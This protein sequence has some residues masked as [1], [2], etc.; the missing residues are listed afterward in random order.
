MASG[1]IED[2]VEREKIR[3]SIYA[4]FYK[5]FLSGWFLGSTFF[6]ALSFWAAGLALRRAYGTQPE[7]A[8][9]VEMLMFMLACAF[10]AMCIHRWRIRRLLR[11]TTI[12][13]AWLGHMG[14]IWFVSSLAINMLAMHALRLSVLP[15]IPR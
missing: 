4:S 3:V 11:W 9:S 10:A 1:T 14:L 15:T 8:T 6:Y 5:N 7:R 2:R 13:N 12:D